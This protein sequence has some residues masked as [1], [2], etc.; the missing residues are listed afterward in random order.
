RVIRT[1]LRHVVEAV[2]AEGSRP[3]GLLVVGAACEA[4]FERE[5]GRA[6]VVEEG[7]GGFDS[8]PD[9]NWMAALQGAMGGDA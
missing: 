5:K 2:D 6:W 3:P 7:F 8:G 4:L 1:T 9:D